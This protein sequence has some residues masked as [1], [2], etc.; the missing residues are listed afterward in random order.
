MK[1]IPI[2]SSLN[3]HEDTTMMVGKL[4]SFADSPYQVYYKD[5]LKKRKPILPIILEVDFMMFEQRDG[6]TETVTR[7]V[8]RLRKDS[9]GQQYERH[10]KPI[11]Y[12]LMVK[13]NETGF[14]GY[15]YKNKRKEWD[16]TL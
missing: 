15:F 2:K 6:E 4:S 8:T 13:N 5:I 16:W 11:I 3:L 14:T 12:K 10:M 7:T 9:I 1:K